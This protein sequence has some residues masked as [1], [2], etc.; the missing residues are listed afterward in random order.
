MKQIDR[1]TLPYSLARSEGIFTNILDAKGRII[2]RGAHMN[3]A[4]DIVEMSKVMALHLDDAAYQPLTI[5]LDWSPPAA[6]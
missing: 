2:I 6:S 4:R 1:D 3:V 5:Q